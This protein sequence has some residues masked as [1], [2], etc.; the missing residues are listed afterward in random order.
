LS[1][2]VHTPEQA[3]EWANYRERWIDIAFRTNPMTE[4]EK[5]LCSQAISDIY[6]LINKDS[7]KVVFVDSPLMAEMVAACS[8]TII[9]TTDTATR[10]ATWAA[11]WAATWDA[12]M[13]ATDAATYSVTYS[14]TRAATKAATDAATEAATWAATYDATNSAT[15]YATE[16]ATWAATYYATIAATWA[17]TIAATDAATHS[18]ISDQN[19]DAITNGLNWYV[20]PY[21]IKDICQNIA[22]SKSLDAL[23]NINSLYQGGNQWSYFHS[24]YEWFRH[25]AKL[26]INWEPWIPWNTLGEH[27]GPRYVHEKFVIISDFPTIL[28]VD[29]ENRPHSSTGPFCQWR[30]GFSLYAWHGVRVPA[31]IIEQP[32]LITIE[33]IEAESNAEIRR[34]MMDRYGFLKCMGSEELD[35]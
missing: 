35:F 8:A 28:K 25:V 15:Y 3:A 7:P 21:P 1:K 26:D 34:V 4:D 13:D 19:S 30:D 23:K 6:R 27:S 10:D 32:E 18:A 11:T 33:K 9:G 12:T 31:W 24:F 2:F 29:N 16:A 5:V 20:V 14:A 22:G 17:A